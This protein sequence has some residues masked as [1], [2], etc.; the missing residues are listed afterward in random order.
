MAH[1]VHCCSPCLACHM[2][3]KETPAKGH[4]THHEVSVGNV[5]LDHTSTK[6]DHPRALGENSLHVDESKV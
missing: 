6:D 5:V 3:A 4:P 1:L 2:S